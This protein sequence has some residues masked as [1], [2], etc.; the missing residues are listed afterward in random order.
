M[1]RQRIFGFR[2]GYEGLIARYGHTPMV[3][4]PQS[5]SQIHNFGG[6]ILGTSRGPQDI[7]GQQVPAQV[8]VLRQVQG[9]R[10]VVVEIGPNDV[11]WTDFLRYCYGVPDCSDRLTQGEFDYRLAA[12]DR[13]YG[14]LLI[15][16]NELPGRRRMFP[17]R[18]R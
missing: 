4:K 14:D 9:L 8:G 13:V 7:G 17:K 6:T 12:F 11:G 1:F 10:F 3:L 2:Y 5:V 15:D 18:R 16:L